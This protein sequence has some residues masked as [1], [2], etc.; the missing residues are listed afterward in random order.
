MDDETVAVSLA[1]RSYNIVIGQRL[2]E[3]A[4]EFLR[5]H[6][7]RNRVFVVT[8]RNV[9]RALGPRLSGSLTRAG[10]EFHQIALA[11]GEGAKS[12]RQLERLLSKLAEL[13]VERNDL[14]AAFGGGVVGDLA[15]F[16]AAV[17]MRGCRFAQL[18]T[19]LLAQVDSAVGGKTGVNLAA[20]KNLAGAF[21]QPVLVLSDIDALETL[22]ERE[23][24]AGLAE[25]VKYGALGD[26]TFFDW[27]ERDAPQIVGRDPAALMRAI[28]RSCTMKAAIVAEDEREH[29]RRALLNLGHT[30]AH[31]LEAAAGYSDQLL[32]GEAVAAGMGLAFDYSVDRLLCPAADAARLKAL[33]RRFGLPA[34]LEGPAAAL[35][36]PAD[37]LSLMRADKKADGGLTLVLV[38]RLGEAF[39]A[40]RADEAL[41]LAFLGGKSTE[42]T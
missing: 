40:P 36:D 25:I 2:I 12:L 29:G 24:R 35:A 21:H 30:F 11:P 7:S 1:D 13:G 23:F 9:R 22:P 37:L 17:Y 27:I 3:R 20:G 39:L 14:I 18:A 10:I 31:A 34:G 16:A 4:G 33:L 42:R 28:R 38:R 8:D 19:S 41:L 15:G 5:P 32:H 6:L 26:S